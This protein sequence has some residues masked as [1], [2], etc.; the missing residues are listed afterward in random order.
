MQRSIGS[1][2]R[3]RPELWAASGHSVLF[4]LEA[5]PV[6]DEGEQIV[7]LQ[8]WFIVNKCEAA[9]VVLDC[10]PPAIRASASKSTR[11][12]GAFE[13]GSICRR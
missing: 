13:S 12:T 10:P 3:H 4:R 7:L 11:N 5:L 6:G 2:S 1:V 9:P 8:W